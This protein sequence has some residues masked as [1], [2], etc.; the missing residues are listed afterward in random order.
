MYSGSGIVSKD[1]MRDEDH[2]DIHTLSSLD[3]DRLAAGQLSH[4]L[5]IRE[6]KHALLRLVVRRK[7]VLLPRLSQES[8][9]CD[10]TRWQPIGPCPLI[11]MLLVDPAP[12][13]QNRRA[14]LTLQRCDN[15]VSIRTIAHSR[16]DQHLL[17][18]S[19]MARCQHAAIVKVVNSIGINGRW[20]G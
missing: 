20:E 7:H 11:S 16:S 2:E 12:V 8:F 5:H 18:M 17:V 4:L 3:P 1:I 10:L 6:I 15:H 14:V 13:H 19:E 9:H